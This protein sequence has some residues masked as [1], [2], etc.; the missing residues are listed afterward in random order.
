MEI[1][2][3]SGIERHDH[4]WKSV[5]NSSR[6]HMYAA[7]TVSDQRQNFQLIQP[8]I[9]DKGSYQG[10]RPVYIESYSS[11]FLPLLLSLA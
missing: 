5:G 10:V 8:R 6:S 7:T 4:V 1:T 9:L 2:L 11:S 3:I